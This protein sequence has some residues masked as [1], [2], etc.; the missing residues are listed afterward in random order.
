M[1]REKIEALGVSVH[2]SKSTAEID[3]TPQGLQLVFTDGERL[4]TDM[5]V[6][7]AGIRPQDALARGA[8]LR[9]G[10]RGGVCIDNH[11]LT[12]DADVFAIGECALWD[13]RGVRAGCAG[14]PDGARGGSAVGR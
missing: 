7:S 4:E 3:S 10:E 13:G 14:L 11:C 2:Y 1:L 8:G 5:V 12:S 6:F 9:I